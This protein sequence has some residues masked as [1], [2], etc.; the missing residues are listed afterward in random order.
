MTALVLEELLYRA[1]VSHPRIAVTDAGGKEFDEAAALAM[2]TAEGLFPQ[3]ARGLL[4]SESAG[5][6]QLRDY[7][8]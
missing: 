7:A 6:R 1:R 4:S 3:P 2:R 5:R 8:K